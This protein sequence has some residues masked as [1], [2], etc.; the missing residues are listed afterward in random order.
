M[1]FKIKLLSVTTLAFMFS[2]CLS[3]NMADTGMFDD[4]YDIKAHLS[5]GEDINFQDEDG[6]SA[7]MNSVLFGHL[8]NVK[9]LLKKGANL[10]LQDNSGSRAFFKLFLF[11]EPND[12]EIL[13]LLLAK[14]VNVNQKDEDGATALFSAISYGLDKHVEMLLDKGADITILNSDGRSP[15]SGLCLLFN[16]KKSKRVIDSLVKKGVDLNLKDA[17][18]KTISSYGNCQNNKES[19]PYLKSKGLK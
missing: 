10:E 12:Q 11:D 1:K 3:L 18:G 14:G 5:K 9:Y 7:L 6:S 15:L 17:K 16:F 4:L 8:D 19:F 2:G 13:D